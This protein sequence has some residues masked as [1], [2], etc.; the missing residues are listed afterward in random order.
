MLGMR[1]HR[2][3]A[4]EIGSRKVTVTVSAGRIPECRAGSSLMSAVDFNLQIFEIVLHCLFHVAGT[5]RLFRVECINGSGPFVSSDAVQG[6]TCGFDQC[7]VFKIRRRLH[8]DMMFPAEFAPARHQCGIDGNRL[9][10]MRVFPQ[11]C[12]EH[13]KI[14]ETGPPCIIQQPVHKTVSVMRHHGHI[15]TDRHPRSFVRQRINRR[16]H[17][18]GIAG[19]DDGIHSGTG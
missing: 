10:G 9:T 4:D 2:L 16:N 15:I 3:R 7:A 13:H 1:D 18:G 17:A 19:F 6:I 5:P 14:A 11:K 12:A 8:N